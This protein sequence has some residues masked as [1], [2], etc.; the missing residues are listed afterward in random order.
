MGMA[1][2]THTSSGPGTGSVQVHDLQQPETKN[3]EVIHRFLAGAKVGA[4][5]A[6]GLELNYMLKNSRRKILY[7]GAAAQT[8]I[9]LNAVNGGGG[10][11]ITNWGLGVGARYNHVFRLYDE[12][13]SLGIPG[14]S[15]EVVWYKEMGPNRNWYINLRAATIITKEDFW[16]DISFGIFLPLNR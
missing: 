13:I 5:F 3:P 15:P 14:Y 1:G 8:S 10:V 7:L 9:V 4:L 16:P 6:F 12:S 2:S 11:F